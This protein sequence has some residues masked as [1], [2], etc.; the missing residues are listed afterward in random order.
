MRVVHSFGSVREVKY[1]VFYNLLFT[2]VGSEFG[3]D[4]QQS[5]YGVAQVL[6]VLRRDFGVEASDYFFVK[7]LHVV[8][9]ERRFQSRYFV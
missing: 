7:A 2:A 9:S 5:P 6:T 1:L 4:L 3:V 8:G